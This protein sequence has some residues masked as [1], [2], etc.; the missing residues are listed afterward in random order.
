MKAEIYLHRSFKKLYIPDRYI[1]LK[2]LLIT[3]PLVLA[4]YSLLPG[5]TRL[6]SSSAQYT[7]SPSGA[8]SG[9]EI[10]QKS[11][12]LRDISVLDFPQGYSSPTFSLILLLVSLLSIVVILRIRI[13]KPVVLWIVFISSINIVSSIF[14]ILCPSKFPYDS[15][16]FSELYVLTE[17]NIWFLAPVITG[18]A[19]TPL[20]STLFSKLVVNIS[21]LFYSLVF[22]IVRYA[23]FLNIL[24]KIS[25]LFMAVLFFAFGPLLDFFYM[26]G[27][28]S[29]YL[30]RISKKA[31][32]N[33]EIWKWSF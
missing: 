29:F 23:V 27:I 14:F 22:G 9:T 17:I 26:V 1:F 11:Y 13:P 33:L 10:F 20:P 3:F 12:L 30:C 25:F 15:R 8:S 31:G 32:N 28:Y 5:L 6:M 7:F 2:F 4:V 16:Q 19:I 18:M 24:S 21:V